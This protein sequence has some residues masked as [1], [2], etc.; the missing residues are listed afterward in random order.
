MYFWKI[1]KLNEQLI[2]GALKESE[3]FKYLM[4]STIM[5]M[6]SM[7]RYGTANDYDTYSGV[8]YLIIGVMGL[9]YVYKCNGG[10]KG[11]LFLERYLSLS[12]VLSIRLIVLVLIPLLVISIIVE[13]VYL[14]GMSEETT[15]IDTTLIQVF[16]II[17]IFWL[18]KH[19]KYVANNSNA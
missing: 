19:I 2:T 7:I 14:G 13:E 16:T 1:K 10:E 15:L 9:W 11:T 4:A 6:L 17:Y 8:A 5:Y 3:K 18:A 12:W